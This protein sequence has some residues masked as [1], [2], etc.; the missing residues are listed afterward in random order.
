VKAEGRGGGE[1]GFPSVLNRI[2]AGRALFSII[3][4]NLKRKTKR[5][6]K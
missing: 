1:G 4:T 2:A 6:V 3:K 5:R